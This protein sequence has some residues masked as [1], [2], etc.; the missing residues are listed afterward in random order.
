MLVVVQGLS[1]L[2]P[3]DAQNN[4]WFSIGSLGV[5]LA[6][7]ACMPWV[8]R[9]VLGLRPLPAGPLR[10]RLTAA[11]R[12]LRLRYSDILLWNTHGGVANA[13]VVG[14]LPMPRYVVLSDRLLAGLDDDE[15]EAVFGHEVGH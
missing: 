11:A 1:R 8:L 7:F 10:D 9:L 15:I 4:E 14:V 2:L 13:M 12:R 3:A 6:V 5:L